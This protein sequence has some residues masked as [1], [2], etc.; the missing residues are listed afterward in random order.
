V[1]V[2]LAVLA[3]ALFGLIIGAVARLLVP[4]RQPMGLMMTSILGILGSLLGGFIAW[5]V[6][7]GEPLQGSNWLMSLIG[8]VVLLAIYISMQRRGTTGPL[9]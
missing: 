4:G 7:G 8:A 2:L 6:V 3:W 9:R 5:M 1:D